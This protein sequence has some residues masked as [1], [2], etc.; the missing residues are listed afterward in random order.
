MIPVSTACLINAQVTQNIFQIPLIGLY[1]F[2]RP[3]SHTTA[4]DQNTRNSTG[5]RIIIRTT[6]FHIGAYH[7]RNVYVLRHFSGN[8]DDFFFSFS[9]IIYKRR[10]IFIFIST[11]KINIIICHTVQFFFYGTGES[12]CSCSL[13][14]SRKLPVQ[15]FSVFQAETSGPLLEF[16]RT[17]HFYDHYC[18]CDFFHF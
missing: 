18:P 1:F 3:S 10:Q 14:I 13:L 4:F 8:L 2:S 5:R 12:L 15:I 11:V 7:I 16:C 17:G 6:G 9:R